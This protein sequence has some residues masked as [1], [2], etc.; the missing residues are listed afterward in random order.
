MGEHL[1]AG[2]LNIRSAHAMGRRPRRPAFGSI[3]S[4]F[5]HPGPGNH[6]T[7]D[8]DK[9]LRASL[10]GNHLWVAVFLDRAC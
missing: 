1:H 4:H 10:G 3:C 8:V 6:V 7:L 2:N 9:F 5:Q